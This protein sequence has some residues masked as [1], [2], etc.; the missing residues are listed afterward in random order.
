MP[1]KHLSSIGGYSSGEC[2]RVVPVQ[3][4]SSCGASI[5]VRHAWYQ[6]TPSFFISL[7]MLV[8]LLGSA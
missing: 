5:C 1:T 3:K 7:G 8:K 2:V 6:S 4:Y